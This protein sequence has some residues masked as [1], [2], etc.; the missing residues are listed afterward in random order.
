MRLRRFSGEPG[1]GWP[2]SPRIGTP[3]ARS[4][5][6]TW[7]S[8]IA[9]AKWDWLKKQASWGTI[10]ARDQ[11]FFNEWRGKLGAWS[12]ARQRG[13]EET[14]RKIHERAVTLGEQTKKMLKAKGGNRF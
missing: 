3:F 11:R 10:S 8:S 7:L 9:R 12:E 6:Q 2:S 14:G 4:T 1:M 13:H 5:R